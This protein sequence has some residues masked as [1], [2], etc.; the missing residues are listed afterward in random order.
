MACNLRSRWRWA[1]CHYEA[2]LSSDVHKAGKGCTGKGVRIAIVDTAMELTHEDLQANVLPGQ[3]FNFTTL[4]NDTAPAPNQA[5]VDHGTAVAG[6]A[7]GRGW[8]GLGSRGTAPFASLVA[9]PVTDVNP[10]DGLSPDTMDYL[11]FGASELAGQQPAVSMFSGRSNTVDVFNYS[12]GRDVGAPESIEPPD[13]WE[14]AMTFGVKNRRNGKGA[15]YLQ[16]AGNEHEGSR[17]FTLPD[18]STKAIFCQNALPNLGLPGSFK[19]LGALSCGSPNQDYRG[20]ETKYLIAALHNSGRAASYSSAGSS[21]WVSGFGGEDGADQAAILTTDNA[22][23][24]SG[25]NNRA[26]AADW[27]AEYPEWTKILADLFGASTKDPNCNYTGRM[28][29]T[30]AATP[31]VSGVVA[32]MLEAN[33]SL[34]WRDVG[35]ILARTAR[36]VDANIADSSRQPRYLPNGNTVGWPLDLPWQTNAAG[37]NFQ[38]H[39]GFGMVD[40]RAAVNMAIGFTAPQGRRSTTLVAPMVGTSTTSTIDGFTAYIGVARFSDPRAVQGKLQVDLT[41]KNLSGAPLNVGGLQ[42]EVIN[43]S[44]GTRSIVMPAFTAWFI[45][46]ER[47]NGKLVT[48][49]TQDLRLFTNA[50]FGESLAGDFEVRVV[51]VRGQAQGLTFT[52]SLSAHS[53]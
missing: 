6:V 1:A 30:S 26:N 47:E 35:Y 43:R 27:K 22:G 50:F 9:F 28:N 36:K 21:V 25:H 10:H 46:G 7:A 40:A 41:L 19:N 29:G 4:G 14:S 23:C 52:A 38:S 8:N 17:A 34:T 53:L 2:I 32:L 45:S 44:S 18:G 12:A 48:G 5:A 42:F 3:S 31:S 16:A 51:D 37:Y 49:G 39:Y 15:V 11:A 20:H 33:P 13:S 24:A